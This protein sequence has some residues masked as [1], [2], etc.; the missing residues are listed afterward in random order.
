MSRTILRNRR[1]L[2]IDEGGIEISETRDS[3]R[4]VT[5]ILKK[6]TTATTG[7]HWHELKTENLQ[8]LQGH[9]RVTIGDT[10][11]VFGPEDGV[12]TIPRYTP[13][14]FGRADDTIEGAPSR[15]IDLRIKEWT[16]PPDGDKEV[17]FR[18]ILGVMI[19][20]K[21]GLL[22]NIKVLLSL[23]V[24]MDAHDNFPVVVKGPVFFG[25]GVQAVVRRGVTYLVKGGLGF[26]GRVF[27]L[28]GSYAEYTPEIVV[29]GRR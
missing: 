6:G 5:L 9:A 24:I 10:T 18:N 28:K 17:F 23:F 8:I 22:G 13:H 25:K 7:L 14:E 12:I 3:D 15:D 20:R 2:L 26:V 27:G 19:D 1:T 16:N 4:A 11:A 29:D 21:S